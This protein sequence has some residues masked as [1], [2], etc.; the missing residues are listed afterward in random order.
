[1][2]G[3]RVSRL[4]APVGATSAFAIHLARGQVGKAVG[5]C[6]DD[7]LIVRK[8]FKCTSDYQVSSS[9]PN[10]SAFELGQSSCLLNTAPSPVAALPILVLPSELKLPIWVNMNPSDPTVVDPIRV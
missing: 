6:L 3:R 9:I 7:L 4:V 5:P 1:M 2:E 10:F 8:F